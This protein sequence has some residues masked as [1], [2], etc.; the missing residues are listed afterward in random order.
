VTDEEARVETRTD[1]TEID[2]AALGAYLRHH[3]AGSEVAEKMAR[4][5]IER[6]LDPDV[7]SFLTR[8]VDSLEEERAI[9][10]QAIE[11]LGEGPG[12]I[13]RGVGMAT[14]VATKVKDAVPGGAPSDLEGLE[15]L[16]VGVWGKR[17]LWG[18]LKTLA[19]THDGFATFPLD[20]LGEQAENQERE[21]IRLR[22]RSIAASLM[23]QPDRD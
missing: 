3:V 11:Q 1:R 7:R 16:A 4:S 5:L 15:A 14:G 12:L 13:E 22:Q 17:L 9:V 21:L 6:E 8:F 10:V 20:E 23:R 2:E 19:A 18:T